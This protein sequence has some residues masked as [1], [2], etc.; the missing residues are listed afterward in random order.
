MSGNRRRFGMRLLLLNANTTP[1]MTARMAEAAARRA[2]PGVTID[3]A[4]ARFGAAYISTRSAAAVA[5]HAALDVLASEVG[6]ANPRGYGAVALA[7]FGDPGLLALKEISPIPVIGM[8]E[9]ALGMAAQIGGRIGIVT[10][11][12]RW[13]PMLRELAIL[14]GFGERV[15]ALRATRLTGAE[16][17]ADPAAAGDE[18][19]ALA[20]ACVA[21]DGADVVILGGAGLA[22][23]AGALQPRLGVP[24]LCSL[25]CLTVAALA[26]ARLGAAKASQGSFAPPPAAPNTGLAPPLAA[27]LATVP[28][29]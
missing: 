26:A 28:A 14:L 5:G 8:A 3:A 13:V 7:C 17:A 6:T 15:V 24:L 27:M 29:P 16:I 23:M 20:T 22:G 1:A 11:G 2:G 18:L 19:A 25:D 9:A 12:T 21:R 4:T 10:G